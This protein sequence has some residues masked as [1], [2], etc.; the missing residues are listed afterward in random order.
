MDRAVL[1]ELCR[2]RHLWIAAG[3]GDEPVGFLAAHALD[4][5]FFIEELSV[6]RS[7]QRQGLGAALVAAAVDRA[8]IEDFPSAVLTTYRDLPWNGPFYARHGF[9][10]IDAS[11][12]GS[13]IAAK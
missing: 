10:E 12:V 6:A 5:E 2:D 4:G 11:R 7:H 13:W 1:A 9:V 8:R 3:A